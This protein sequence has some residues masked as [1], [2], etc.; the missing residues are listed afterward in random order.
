M[1]NK[2]NL[3]VVNLDPSIGHEVKKRRPCVI[4]SPD[5]M[6]NSVKTITIAPLTTTEKPIPTRVLIKACD[7]SGLDN[8]SYAMLDQIMSIDQSRVEKIIGSVSDSE[9][10]DITDR[11][12][13]LFAR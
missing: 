3:I 12:L 1:Y 9:E 4:I 7:D 8:D 13:E 2:F 10:Q 5:E 6:N 11:L